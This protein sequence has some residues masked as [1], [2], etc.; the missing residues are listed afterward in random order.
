MKQGFLKN[1]YKR[2]RIH[3]TVLFLVSFLSITLF[4]RPVPDAPPPVPTPEIQSNFN[5]ENHS[6]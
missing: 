3:C 4:G 1:Q 6:P 5:S 2:I